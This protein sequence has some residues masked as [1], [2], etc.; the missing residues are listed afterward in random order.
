MFLRIYSD[1]FTQHITILWLMTFIFY[2]FSSFNESLT[3]W[4]YLFHNVAKMGST[5]FDWEDDK[6]WQRVYREGPPACEWVR[7]PPG[8]APSWS[9]HQGSCLLLV[10]NCLLCQTEWWPPHC[11]Y[12]CA[13][14]HNEHLSAG[15]EPVFRISQRACM[16]GNLMTIFGD[17]HFNIQTLILKN[18]TTKH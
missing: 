7:A 13:W 1:G 11:T 6:N 9:Q 17:K 14:S 10:Q 5:Y 18:L 3:S 16:R 4:V 15:W 8:T 2:F 12:M